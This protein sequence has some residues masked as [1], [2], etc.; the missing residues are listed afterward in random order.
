LYDHQFL[1]SRPHLPEEGP[2]NAKPTVADSEA[3]EASDNQDGD[4]VEGSLE[5]SHST[6]SPPPAECET[7]GA[8]KKRKRAKDLTSSGTSNPKDVAQE[9][10]TSKGSALDIFELLD[11]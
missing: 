8:E 4:E 5:G 9:Q 6:L 2:I 7:Q 11:S 3:P 10:T 1:V